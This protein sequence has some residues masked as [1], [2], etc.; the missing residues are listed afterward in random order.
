MVAPPP[1]SQL[2]VVYFPE[3]AAAVMS[4]ESS[5]ISFIGISGQQRMAI[6]KPLLFT[7]LI[8]ARLHPH[9]AGI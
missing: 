3:G 6:N 9:P 8:S 4:E 5:Q 2:S 7:L 1:F